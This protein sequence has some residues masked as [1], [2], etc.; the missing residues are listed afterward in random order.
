M[1]PPPLRPTGAGVCPDHQRGPRRQSRHAGSHLEAARHDRV[2]IGAPSRLRVR[3]AGSAVSA[4]TMKSAELALFAR[5]TVH[6][7]PDAGMSGGLDAGGRLGEG[8]EL[9]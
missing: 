3:P 6:K 7:A 8:V 2:G 5:Y 9:V 4:K 1:G